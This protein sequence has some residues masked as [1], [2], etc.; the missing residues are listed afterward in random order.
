MQLSH[1]QKKLKDAASDFQAVP[2]YPEGKTFRVSDDPTNKDRNRY[3]DIQTYDDTRVFLMDD[4]ND[5]INANNVVIPVAGRQ[6]WYIAAQGP[7]PTTIPH[8]WNM[9]WEQ[10]SLIIVMLTG[11]T[12]SGVTKCE[13]Y[14]PEKQGQTQQYGQRSV[15][16]LKLRMNDSFVLR[17][18][19]VT[20]LETQESRLVWQLHY[21]AW[22]DHGVPESESAM[23]EFVDELRAVRAKY[24]PPNS[25]TAPWPIVVHCSAGIGRTGVLM[26]LEIALAKIEAGESVDMTQIISDLREQRFGLIQRPEQYS[27][28]SSCLI[29]ALQNSNVLSLAESSSV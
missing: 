13:Q 20:D 18:L 3:R 12:E 2:K 26:A 25:P 19:Q 21:T 9:I 14:W 16:L 17:G 22:P 7:N 29:S 8:F 5:Y 6:F 4:E 27:F 24:I 28:V 10:Q 15:T 11:C 23:L 1:L